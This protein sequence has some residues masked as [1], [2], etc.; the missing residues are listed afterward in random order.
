MLACLPRGQQALIPNGNSLTILQELAQLSA[1][2]E[3][4]H[5]NAGKGHTPLP[6]TATITTLAYSAARKLGQELHKDNIYTP[7]DLFDKLSNHSQNESCTHDGTIPAKSS[8]FLTSMQWIWQLLTRFKQDVLEQGIEH[9]SASDGN[10]C[11]FQD[12][13]EWFGMHDSDS[14]VDKTLAEKASLESILRTMLLR[15]KQMRECS[16]HGRYSCLQ[17]LSDLD[18]YLRSEADTNTAVACHVTFGLHLL[19]RSYKAYLNGCKLANRPWKSADANPRLQALTLTRNLKSELK[20]MLVRN[21]APCSCLVIDG[22]PVISQLNAL[23]RKYDVFLSTPR[24]ELLIQSP[25][26]SGEHMIENLA[27]ASRYGFKAWHHGYYVGLVSGFTCFVCRSI[28]SLSL[29]R[30]LLA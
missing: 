5:V 13:F 14:H 25:W 19:L 28:L 23:Y 12:A 4:I 29:F 21:D 11:A 16:N 10:K 22:A 7:Q 6:I 26:I 2:V 9:V 18:A 20:A 15:I 3:E 30:A 1:Y 24:F 8:V 17:L 27:F